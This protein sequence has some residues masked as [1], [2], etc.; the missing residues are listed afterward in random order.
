[1]VGFPSRGACSAGYSYSS[2][3]AKLFFLSFIYHVLSDILY[4][5]SVELSSRKIESL[6]TVFSEGL[7]NY[8]NRKILG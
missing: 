7:G 8:A 4:H 1:M 3:P 6:S 2:R 5:A